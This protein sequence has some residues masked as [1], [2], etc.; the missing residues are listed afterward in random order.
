MSSKNY[1]QSFNN[2]FKKSCK[3]TIVSPHALKCSIV[4]K[5]K[6]GFALIE[7]LIAITIL[8][9]SLIS[10]VSGVSGG[11]IAVSRNKNLTRA[12]II[13]KNKINEF[14]MNNMRGPDIKNEEVKEYAG[15]TFSREV[16]RFEHELFGPLDAKRIEIR[17]N[18]QEKGN[19]KE[20]FISY[21]YP[22]K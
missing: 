10:I 20:Y 2:A 22:S 1:N 18:W 6:N 17:V 12:M 19:N 14:E 11:I 13:A 15:F 4:R 3:K 8:S 16:K 5:G 21:I 7:I 9:I